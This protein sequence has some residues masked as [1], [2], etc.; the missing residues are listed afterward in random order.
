MWQLT[1]TVSA[2]CAPA[3]GLVDVFG[4]LFPCGSVTG[5]PKVRTMQIIAEL[6]DS[7]RGVYCGAVGYLAPPVRAC[8]ALGSTSPIRTVIVDSETGTAEYG[9]GGGITWDSRAA[10]EYEEI[11]AKA[12]VLTSRRPHFELFET[13]RHEPG[14]GYRHLDR[15]LA[16]LRAPPRT[17]GSGST[18]RSSR[19]PSTRG[20]SCAR[21]GRARARGGRSP[22]PC[23]DGRRARPRSPDLVRVE[24]DHGHPVDPADPMLFHKTT[25]RRVYDDAKARHPDADDVLLVNTRGELTESTIANVAVRLD[26]AW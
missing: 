11:V 7:P 1:S 26:G 25:R 5:A 20:R 21:S 8:Q 2:R 23:G 10:G 18:R 22:R 13:L 12:R 6:E 4:A 9:V 19:R 14:E 15:H 17:S 16:R 24:L 3:A